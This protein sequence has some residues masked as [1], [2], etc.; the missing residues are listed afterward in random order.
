MGKK[1]SDRY[2]VFGSLYRHCYIRKITTTTISITDNHIE[3]INMK[4]MLILIGIIVSGIAIDQAT[5]LLVDG[6]MELHQSIAV[7]PNV[8]SL[9]YIRNKG[10][11]FGMLSEH[12]WV[13][14]II[15]TIAIVAMCVYL[16]RFC[17]EKM[18]FK[19]GLALVI[20]GGIGNMI[21]RVLYGYVIDMIEAT[22]IEK[23]FGVSFAVFNVADSLVCVGAGL[24]IFCLIREIILDQG[25][26]K[27]EGKSNGNR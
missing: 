6:L 12:R 8:F 10:A 24:V 14:M 19:V 20:S 11:A 7:I 1:T 5:K 13:F 3:R 22:F 15:S 2:V 25:K 16:F 27:K 4:I 17:K 23:L 21:D 18:L 9:T 26:N